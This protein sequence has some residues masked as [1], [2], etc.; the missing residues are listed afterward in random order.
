MSAELCRSHHVPISD[1][2][3]MIQKTVQQRMIAIWSC[4]STCLV[5]PLW[6][7]DCHHS[8]VRNNPASASLLLAGHLMQELT[9]TF[10]VISGLRRAPGA[11]HLYLSAALLH[12]REDGRS[13]S[14]AEML[15]HGGLPAAVDPA[16]CGGHLP[17]E[18]PL[19]ATGAG[20][21]CLR[22]LPA[23]RTCFSSACRPNFF[24]A[25]PSSTLAAWLAHV[26]VR[27]CQLDVDIATVCCVALACCHRHKFASFQSVRGPYRTRNFRHRMWR[28][29]DPLEPL[30]GG[31][32]LTCAVALAGGGLLPKRH[33]PGAAA[34]GDDGG[35]GPEPRRRGGRGAGGD[36]GACPGPDVPQHH[37]RR[38][39]RIEW[40]VA[41]N[42]AGAIGQCW[43]LR[44][45]VR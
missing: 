41:E 33:Q 8:T 40:A 22:L 27:L 14:V 7:M 18:R 35:G 36:I 17:A 42:A 38:Q 26:A 45:G 44:C 13:R 16:S 24:G 34:A 9:C 2:P 20:V 28:R 30:N 5:A 25:T 39:V 3:K 12:T 4:I 10:P 15:S 31:R 6:L 43:I 19:S 11:Q 29:G 23:Q 32:Q 37:A 1:L 21:L